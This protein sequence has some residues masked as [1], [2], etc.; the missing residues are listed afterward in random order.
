[1]VVTA[2]HNPPA[3][4]V[5]KVYLSTGS[6]I[7]SPIDCDISERI[8]TFDPLTIELASPDHELIDHLIADVDDVAGTS[9]TSAQRQSIIGHC[10]CSLARA[11]SIIAGALS[12]AST[13]PVSPAAG[14]E[15][16]Q[17]GVDG[18]QVAG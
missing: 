10:G 15:V 9:R 1:M 5:Y 18:V 4:N 8:A 17:R 16:H 2:S 14:L 13:R 7:V 11:R 3:D 12:T 6:Q